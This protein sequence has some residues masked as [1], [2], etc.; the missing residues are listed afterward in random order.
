MSASDRSASAPTVEIEIPL[1]G[2]DVLHES[3]SPVDRPNGNGYYVF[4]HFQSPVYL[5]G[6][7]GITRQMPRGTGILYQPRSIY[8]YSGVAHEFRH[9]WFHCCGNGVP[10][11]ISRFELPLD[12][13]LELSAFA[14]LLPLL[15]EVRREQLRQEPFWQDAVSARATSFFLDLGRAVK[16][17]GDLH[18][19]PYD[20]EQRESLLRVRETVH[21]DLKRVWTI[22][23]MSALVHL[24]ASRFT[25]L[26]SRFFETSPLQ[27]LIETRISRACSLLRQTSEPVERIASECGFGSAAHFTRLFR[28]RAGCP[29]S[30]YR[31][32]SGDAL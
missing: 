13:P 7:G 15:H 4:I 32:G 5:R 19:T 18:L 23:E 3:V 9:S 24:S 20:R 17:A 22:E 16:Q 2:I 29:P 14:G 27:D 11:C 31:Q 8:W 26:Y 28:Q 1:L 21:S 12:S 6:R 30:R 25:A 10:A